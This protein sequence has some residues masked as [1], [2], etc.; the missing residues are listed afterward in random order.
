MRMRLVGKTARAGQAGWQVGS[1]RFVLLAAVSRALCAAA[2][3]PFEQAVA[4][5][6]SPEPDDRLRAATLL[7]DAAYP[8][9]AIP[10]A[11]A[12]VDPEDAVQF[13]AIA[14][15]LNIFLADK[16]RPEEAGRPRG[17]GSHEDRRR[18][19]LL[20]RAAGARRDAGAARSPD[21]A[22]NGDARQ[23]A[24]S[25][26]S[27]PCTR[28]ARSRPSPRAPRAASCGRRRRPSLPRWWAPRM[29]RFAPAG[30]RVIGRVYSTRTRR[31]TRRDTSVGDAVITAL[32]DQNQLIKLAAMD[33]LGAMRYG[34]AVDALTQLFRVLQAGRARRGG[35]RRAGANRRI[36]RASRSSRRSSPRSRPA[37]KAIAIEGLARSGD[38][39]QM[40]A[41]EAALKGE[42][43][44]RV[45]FAGTFASA[46]LV[47]R[48]HRADRR[49]A[50][51]PEA[52]R[53]RQAVPDRA[54]AGP[55]DRLGRYAQDPDPGVR[56]DIAD[57]LGFS[58]DAAAQPIVES[59]IKDEDKQVAL[60]AE[61]AALRLRGSDAAR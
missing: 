42:H 24:E 20:G 30:V 39:S 12:V 29:R 56:A 58:G 25:R 60:A 19:G 53:A 15:E 13:E 8:E 16:D 1:G 50:P 43:D 55:R 5:L 51:A 35:A 44:D 34:R 11:K 27:R 57:I 9:A 61:R 7:K 59:L 22:A 18:S 17:R 14:A 40:E 49:C 36:R 6:A 3:V 54:R 28:S 52:A 45:I 31:T 2:Q 32:N 4:E 41:I 47:E 26:R 10:L 23:Q 21:R 38:A 37:M 48:V 33:T 46:M